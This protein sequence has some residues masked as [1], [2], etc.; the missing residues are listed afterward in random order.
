MLP[1][2]T[3]S[4]GDAFNPRGTLMRRAMRWIVGCASAVVIGNTATA[5]AAPGKADEILVEILG[6]DEVL[7]NEYCYWWSSVS[8]G[9]PPYTYEWVPRGGIQGLYGEYFLT[10]KDNDFWLDLNVT[11][12][13]G[14]RGVTTLYVNVTSNTGACMI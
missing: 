3:F 2:T 9:T 13:N 14:L 1:H 8:G 4:G 5:A 6:P 7:P 12:A 11:D 10:T